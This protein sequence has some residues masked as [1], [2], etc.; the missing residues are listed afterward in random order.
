MKYISLLRGI[1]VSGQKQIR[2]ADLRMLYESIGLEEV[3]TYIQSGNVMFGSSS[4]NVEEL[5][6]KIEGAIR[7]Q[8]KFEVLV[9]IR[10]HRELASII[11]NCP[12]GPVDEEKDGTRVLVSFLSTEPV[13]GK[14]DEVRRYATESEKLVLKGREVFLYCPNGY[15][16]SKLSNAFLE[17]KLGVVATTRNWKTVSQLYELSC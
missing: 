10:T 2:M 1:N 14:L 8:F 16:K 9:E 12:F 6:S 4:K 5:S 11:K 15:G 13:R 3:T 7:K 17:K